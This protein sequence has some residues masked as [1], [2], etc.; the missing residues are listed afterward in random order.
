[1][2]TTL[3]PRNPIAYQWAPMSVLAAPIDGMPGGQ[4]F[5]SYQGRCLE[6]NTD[7][8]TFGFSETCNPGDL[9]QWWTYL[10]SN[11]RPG[12]NASPGALST[13]GF[14]VRLRL[15]SSVCE[16]NVLVPSNV[17]DSTYWV[18]ENSVFDVTCGIYLVPTDDFTGLRPAQ[19]NQEA[20]QWEVIV[21]TRPVYEPLE[22]GD[23]VISF[24]GK[25]LWFDDD[26]KPAF[27]SPLPS[28]VWHYDNEENSLAILNHRPILYF[29]RDTLNNVMVLLDQ[30]P[31][32]TNIVYEL[33][34]GRI[35]S[36]NTTNYCLDP[37]TLGFQDCLN[38]Q[39]LQVSPAEIIVSP[40]PLD[41][42]TYIIYTTDGCMLDQDARL[43]RAE[44][45]L[46]R[47]MY[48]P[49]SGRICLENNPA[50]CLSWNAECWDLDAA[51]TVGPPNEETTDRFILGE[52]ALYDTVCQAAF[53][54]M[55]TD[56]LLPSAYMSSVVAKSAQDSGQV[57]WYWWFLLIISV[58]AIIILAAL[59]M[60]VWRGQ[61]PWIWGIIAVLAS[62]VIVTTIYIIIQ[63][64]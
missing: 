10:G 13:Y 34:Q 46:V 40:E 62:A 14:G 15:D 63:S 16:D 35:A 6:H 22:T 21:A 60:S 25:N 44:Y 50:L 32:D 64:K 3:D 24:Q 1:M 52:N 33:S 51:L 37:E 30:N 36:L 53:A 42:G 38:V 9:R 26:G 18:T 19:N 17:G 2:I 11:A 27:V 28:H 8:G 31:A 57:A 45:P 4:I 58:L 5:L 59:K 41:E 54:P 49:D 61:K 7:D 23:Y 20:Q 48:L 12:T 55:G 56:K 47:W 29:S 39:E 43:V